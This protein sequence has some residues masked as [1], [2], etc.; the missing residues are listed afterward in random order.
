MAPRRASAQAAGSIAGPVVD[1]VSGAPLAGAD[2]VLDGTSLITATD[3]SGAFRLSAVPAGQYA[4]LAAYLGHKLE[5]AE[6]SVAAGQTLVVE[7]K[8]APA[9]FSESVSVIAEP[10]AEGQAA[11]LNLQRTAPNIVNAVAS[12][13]IGAFPDPNAAEAASRIPAPEGDVRQV[14]LDAVPADQL[15]SIEVTKALT[16]DMDADAIGGAVNLVTRQAV[17]RPTLLASASGGYNAL[18]ESGGQRLFTATAGR[19]FASGRLGLLAGFSGSSLTRGSEN[20]EA[21]YDEGYLADFELRDYQIERERVGFNGSA[22]VR[23]NPNNT[24]MFKG[25]WNRFSDYAVNNRLRFP[26]CNSNGRSPYSHRRRWTPRPSWTSTAPT[27]LRAW[28]GRSAIRVAT[29][30]A[31]LLAIARNLG[32]DR[33]RFARR[34][35]GAE[36]PEGAVPPDVEARLELDRVLRAVR[37]LPAAYGEPLMLVANGLSYEEAGRVM[38]LPVTTVKIRVHRARLMMTQAMTAPP[39]S[40]R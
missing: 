25:I 11:A 32:R 26:R 10:I 34:W 30:K 18:Q 3:R 7:V 27:F 15:Q 31:Y 37:Q 33:R 8:L 39:G 38:N 36:V 40:S 9:G 13:Q 17:G 12:D 14:Q 5:R 1:A 2:I 16:P 20:F 35:P 24:L 22:D 21:E 19:R 6:V 23:L 29:A 4:L 28:A